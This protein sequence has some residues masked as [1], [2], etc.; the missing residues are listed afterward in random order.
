[1]GKT[2]EFLSALE[3]M[4]S[5]HRHTK[6]ALLKKYCN[7]PQAEKYYRNQIEVLDQ[8]YEK[9]FRSMLNEHIVYLEASDPYGRAPLWGAEAKKNLFIHLRQSLEKPK[10]A[11]FIEKLAKSIITLQQNDIIDQPRWP[12]LKLDNMFYFFKSLFSNKTAFS[13]NEQKPKLP[14]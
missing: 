9:K 3:G 11:E 2:R 5:E 4:I 1:M 12:S 14:K 8:K 10:G 13:D 6:Q 7:N